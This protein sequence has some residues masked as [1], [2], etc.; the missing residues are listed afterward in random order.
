[1]VDSILLD[2]KRI[3]PR[4][5]YLQGEYGLNDLFVSVPTKP[6]AGGAEE[7]IEL[8]LSEDERSELEEKAPKTYARWS[9][10]YTASVLPPAA[11]IAILVA[12]EDT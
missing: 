12:V 2:Q 5:A 10:F 1:M 6:G 4:A 7:V 9:R 8:D 3:L 11:T